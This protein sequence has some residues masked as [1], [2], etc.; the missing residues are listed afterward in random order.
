MESVKKLY[1]NAESLVLERYCGVNKAYMCKEILH[2]V[3]VPHGGARS[4]KRNI[5]GRVVLVNIVGLMFL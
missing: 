3:C 2:I 1:A 4:N 5:N